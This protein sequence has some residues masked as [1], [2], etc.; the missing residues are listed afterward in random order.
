MSTSNRPLVAIGFWR[1]MKGSFWQDTSLHLSL[2]V[3]SNDNCAPFCF[4][5]S[6]SLFF[7]FCDMFLIFLDSAA[8]LFD[9]LWFHFYIFVM[10]I[11]LCVCDRVFCPSNLSLAIVVRIAVAAMCVVPNAVQFLFVCWTD[12]FHLH[13]IHSKNTNIFSTHTHTFKELSTGFGSWLIFS[14]SGQMK[15]DSRFSTTL[16]TRFKHKHD[17]RCE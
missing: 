6:P 10:Y 8:P 11:L 1:Q 14:P 4:S 5:C 7:S 16:K 9:D 15:C 17:S 12:S 13:L 2:R 3:Q